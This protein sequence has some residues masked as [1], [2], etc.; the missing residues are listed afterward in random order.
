MA[1]GF[2]GARP[3]Q[4]STSETSFSAL[5]RSGAQSSAAPVL[6]LYQSSNVPLVGVSGVQRS[7]ASSAFTLFHVDSIA[8]CS[9]ACCGF[10]LI[11]FVLAHI[12]T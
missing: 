6:A 10:S 3:L 9:I 4:C 11:G 12:L 7:P 1:F 8:H 5:Y 2:P